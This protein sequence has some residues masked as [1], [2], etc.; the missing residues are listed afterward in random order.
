[1][2]KLRAFLQGPA[3]NAWLSTDG[4]H[5]YLRKGPRRLNR[6]IYEN[7]LDIA[8]V[9][10]RSAAQ[11]GK[12]KFTKFFNEVLLATQEGF[13]AIYIENVLTERFANFFRR[14]GW[15]ESVPGEGDGPPCFYKLMEK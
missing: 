11:E 6:Q 4:M 10:V 8:N 13:D 15:Q 12:G 5:I 1:M 7:V 14:Q 3:R 2:S 9:S